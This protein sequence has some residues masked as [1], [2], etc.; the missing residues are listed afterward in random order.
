MRRRPRA[1]AELELCPRRRRAGSSNGKSTS[2]S[3]FLSLSPI[4]SHQNGT[5]FASLA[6][7]LQQQNA[8]RAGNAQRAAG[9]AREFSP[10]PFDEL[11][12]RNE[13]EKTIVL[14]IVAGKRAGERTTE[15]TNGSW[16]APSNSFARFHTTF[17][18][19]EADQFLSPPPS[20]CRNEVL[21]LANSGHT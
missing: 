19:G 12:G 6:F 17:A 16:S 13:I 5:S 15:R 7:V 20:L 4:S 11:E 18:R 1:L 14:I 2:R 8:K 9:R 3:R 10:R 21:S